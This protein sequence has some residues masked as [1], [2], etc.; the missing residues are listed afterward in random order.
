MSAPGMGA[1]IHMLS[2]GSPRDPSDFYGKRIASVSFVEK[3]EDY[4]T[5][6]HIGFDDGAIIRLWDDGQS[7]CESRYMTCDDDV[8]VLVGGALRR[9]EAKNYVEKDADHGDCH[10]E[11]FVEIA[12]DTA[13]ITLV[14]HNQHN[15]YYGGFGL[16]ID[17][18]KGVKS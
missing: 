15:G 16:S 10:D 1:M 4:K 8:G 18:V 7:C 11:V 13:F 12:T 9:I 3:D 6:L 5:E 14:N 2:G 17:V